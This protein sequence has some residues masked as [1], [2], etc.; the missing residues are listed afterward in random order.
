MKCPRY[1][2]IRKAI[3]VFYI[4]IGILNTR[5]KTWNMFKVGI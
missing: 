4:F 2:N 1:I 3:F 5:K